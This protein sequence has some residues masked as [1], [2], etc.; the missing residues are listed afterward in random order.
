MKI[1]RMVRC[2]WRQFRERRQKAI[3]SI[4][5]AHPDAQVRARAQIIVALAREARVHDIIKT[6]LC[7]AS[8]VYK[9]ARCFL[10][11]CEG[12][13]ADRREDN[14]NTVMTKSVRN[15]VWTGGKD[16]SPIWASSSYVDIGT[17]GSHAQGTHNVPLRPGGTFDNSPAIHRWVPGDHH[18]MRVPEGRLTAVY[19]GPGRP[20]LPSAVPPGLV[21]VIATPDPAINRWAIVGCPSGTRKRPS[22][23]TVTVLCHYIPRFGKLNSS[24]GSDSHWANRSSTSASW[25]LSR[26]QRESSVIRFAEAPTV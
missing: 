13:F 19:P 2:K 25:R 21:Y 1:P 5:K 11:D 17:T 14:G 22:G 10:E 16:A 24:S 9:V 6:L 3:L 15:L 18:L 7:S 23:L 4:A 8:P 20:P 12:A 26:T